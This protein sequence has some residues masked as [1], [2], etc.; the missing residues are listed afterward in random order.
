MKRYSPATVFMLNK[1]IFKFLIIY[2]GHLYGSMNY[3]SLVWNILN[4]E[5]LIVIRITLNLTYSVLHICLYY[6]EPHQELCPSQAAELAQWL[7]TL[8]IFPEDPS[9]VPRIH[10]VAHNHL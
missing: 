9:L 3:L 6:E 5:H 7:S 4:T 8:V 2:D 1:Y 10:M